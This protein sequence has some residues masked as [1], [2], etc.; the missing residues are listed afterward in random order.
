MKSEVCYLLPDLTNDIT[1]EYKVVFDFNILQ[2][3]WSRFPTVRNAIPITTTIHRMR[4]DT[5]CLFTSMHNRGKWCPK[6]P[7]FHSSNTH[8]RTR[9]SIYR[10][11]IVIFCLDRKLGSIR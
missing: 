8:V 4:N 6:A 10:L 5:I 7:V 3:H 11:R 2:G 9:H 1:S